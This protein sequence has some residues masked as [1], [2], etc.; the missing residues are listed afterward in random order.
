M[1]ERI[2]IACDPRPESERALREG[3]RLAAALKSEI[4]LFGICTLDPAILIAEANAPS[5][6]P[7]RMIEEFRGDLE[8]E[9]AQLRE[10]GFAV[11]VHC[12]E[13]EEAEAITTAATETKSDLLV[14]AHRHK[15]ALQKL[16]DPARDYSILDHM[17]CHLLV[18]GDHARG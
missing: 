5:D 13:S 7:A 12:T 16:V 17:R 4:V 1:F 3:V 15:T 9:A 10:Q 6:L 2:M 18:I 14:I 8:D 11:Q